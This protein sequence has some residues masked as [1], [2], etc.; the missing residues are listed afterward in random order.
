MV[1]R[2]IFTIIALA[3]L[4]PFASPAQT[5]VTLTIDTSTRQFPIPPDYS[6][7]G[8][9]TKSVVPNTYG[10]KGY[11]FTPSNTQLITLFQNIGLKNIRVGG[12]MVDGSGTG[13]QCVTPTPTEKDID[14]LFEFARL[15]GIKV[16]YSVR[17]L[18]LARCADPDL[19]EKD[20]KIAAYVWNKY[21]P[22]L[23]SLSIGNE[24]DVREFHQYPGQPHDP[25]IYEATPGI[26]GSAY[27]SYFRD[28]RHFAD[29]ILKAVPDA[30]F[31]GPDTA[32]SAT[33]SFTPNP[34]TG[35]SWTQQFATDLKGARILSAALQHHYVWGGPKNTTAQEATDDML[36]MAWDTATTLGQQPAYNGGHAEF[37]PYPFVYQRILGPVRALGVPYRMT[38]A[39]DCLHGV[40][41]ASDSYPA[42]LWALDYMHWWAAHQMAGVNFH[43]NPWIPTDTIVPD[44]NPCTKE[45][46][47]NFR[48]SPKGYG[49]KAFDLG[50]HGYIEPVTIAK[51]ENFNLTAYAA[52]T[53]RALFVTI[54]NRTHSTT[55]DAAPAAVTIRANGFRSGSASYMLL[56]NGDPGNASGKNATL[57]GALIRNNARWT[58]KWTPLGSFTN[59][60]ITLTVPSTTAAVVRVQAAGTFSGPIQ[61]DQRG[62]LQLFGVKADGRIAHLAQQSAWQDAWSDIPGDFFSRGSLTVLRNEDN[63]LELFTIGSNGLVYHNRQQLPDPSWSGWSPL[64]AEHIA[65]LVSAN[66]ADGSAIL[67]GIGPNGNIRVNSESAPGIGWSGWKDIGGK[68]IQPGFAVGSNPS[69]LLELIGAD[70]HGTIWRSK[71]A[72]D[73]TWKSWTRMD[74]HSGPHLVLARNLDGR[75]ELFAVG[76]NRH[77][78]HAVQTTPGGDWGQMSELDDSSAKPDL[79]QQFAIGQDQEGRQIFFGLRAGAARSASGQIE[80]LSQLTPGGSYGSWTDL[81][82][83]GPNSNI[84]QLALGSDKDGSIVLFARAKDGSLA[85]NRQSAPAGSWSGWIKTTGGQMRFY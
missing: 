40:F 32:V 79:S 47:G 63:S 35:V 60:L 72:E 19:A 29:A 50:G 51:P 4:F 64:G 25:A 61:M 36:S 13:E 71:Q 77:L 31:S 75:L 22:L 30:K 15:A 37:N 85:S 27:P 39:N 17:L 56:T 2:H 54:L 83:P 65:H 78:L 14:N 7:L 52:G 23:D 84:T 81:A 38:E 70:A 74:G 6:G 26:A 1:P 43:N 44:P 21:R 18:N 12:G 16:I 11:F 49:I 10:V 58:G 55:H 34:A 68:G 48:I 46:C 69:G 33:S 5:P 62:E 80:I 82:S 53:D 28:W 66:N 41:G 8:F 9:E 42:A 20:A 59:G 57:G 45:G 24:P 76:K 67:F 3:A 73:Y